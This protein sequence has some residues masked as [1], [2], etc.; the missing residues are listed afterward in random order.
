[1]PFAGEEVI[2]V[3]RRSDL[4]RSG[5]EFAIDQNRIAD[6]RNIAC[7]QRYANHLADQVTIARIVGMN[8]DGGI[9]EHGLGAR[10]GH[11]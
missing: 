10:R 11:D 1:M 9:A 6:N 2:E 8:R 5:A 3:V 4:H 7:R